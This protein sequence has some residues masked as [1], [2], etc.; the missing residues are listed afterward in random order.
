MADTKIKK[1]KDGSDKKKKEIPLWK[2]LIET[3]KLTKYGNRRPNI[4]C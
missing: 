2:E 3:G 1:V 4:I